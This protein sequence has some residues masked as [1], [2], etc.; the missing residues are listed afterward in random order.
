MAGSTRRGEPFSAIE[1]DGACAWKGSFF[2]AGEEETGILEACDRNAENE[3][4]VILE[5][6]FVFLRVG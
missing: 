4:T 2:F 6:E 5:R 1:C 3:G